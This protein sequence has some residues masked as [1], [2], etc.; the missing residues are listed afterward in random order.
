MADD[1]KFGDWGR[2]KTPLEK[3]RA[4]F[5]DG[6]VPEGEQWRRMCKKLRGVRA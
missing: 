3:F 4:R 1:V 2:N 5:G 6:E